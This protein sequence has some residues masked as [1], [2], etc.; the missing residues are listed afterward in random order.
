MIPTI[1]LANT[2]RRE[3]AAVL[4]ERCTDVGFLY[5]TGHSVPL[6]LLEDVLAQSRALF[7]LP[8]HR[9]AALSDRVLNRGYTRLGEETLDPA[10]QTRGDTKEGFYIGDEVSGERAGSCGGRTSGRT[11]TSCRSSDP[12]WNGTA[13]R[14][15]GSAGSW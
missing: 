14:P 11:P 3:V 9:R 1:D 10:N 7:G 6:S 4:S 2:S 8:L 15:T 12:S 13:R 5:L